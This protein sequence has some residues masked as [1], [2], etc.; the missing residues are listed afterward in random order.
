MA[1]FAKCPAARSFL[2]RLSELTNCSDPDPVLIEALSTAALVR[3]CRNFTSG[4]REKLKIE[5]LLTATPEEVV[6]HER[7]R[8][9]RDKHVA[10]PVNQQEV[11]AL[12]LIVDESHDVDYPVL[13]LSS[14]LS[15]SLPLT[16]VEAQLTRGFCVK[17]ITQ[18]QNQLVEE[19]LRLQP[20]A[21]QLSR[22]QILSLPIDEPEPNPN[23]DARRRQ[24]YYK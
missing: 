8:K 1:R 23:V 19:K 15:A 10:H 2:E 17:W 20:F 16:L 21:A 24:G 9:I 5:I 14:Y 7:L 11:D 22:D 4:I 13:G 12:Y 3:Y 18:L 6:L